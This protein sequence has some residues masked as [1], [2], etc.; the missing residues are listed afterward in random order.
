MVMVTLP[1]QPTDRNSNPPCGALRPPGSEAGDMKRVSPATR[2]QVAPPPLSVALAKPAMP[3]T[4]LARPSTGLTWNVC[5]TCAAGKKLA[6]PVWS[7]LMVQV[8]A[9]RKLSAPPDVMAHTPGVAELKATGKAELAVAVRVPVV[10]KLRGPG[11]L[12]LMVCAL[13]GVA[14]AEAADAGPVPAPLVAVTVKV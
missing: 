7:A 8:P 4:V 5:A 1:T 3:G 11:L 14:G 10:P 6:L 13:R 12:K 2:V 9:V